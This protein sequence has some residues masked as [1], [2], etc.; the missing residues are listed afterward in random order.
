MNKIVSTESE[1]AQKQLSIAQ[2]DM[3]S[4]IRS[5]PKLWQPNCSIRD[6]K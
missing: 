4:L 2:N 6:E 5:T 1:K 3:D